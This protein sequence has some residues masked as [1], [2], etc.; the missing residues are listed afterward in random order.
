[1]GAGG[2]EMARYRAVLRSAMIKQQLTAA[3][4]SGVEQVWCHEVGGSRLLHGVSIRQ[5]FPGHPIQA[6]TIAA[7]CGASVYASKFIVVVDEDVDVTNLDHLMWAVV[8]RTEPRESIHFID[9]SWDS[10]ADP[11]LDPARRAAK[12]P[13]HSVAVID[14]CRPWHWRDK[15]APA[16][17]P[18]AETTRLARER[19]GWLIDGALREKAMR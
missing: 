17:S 11:R 7:Q 14:A 9:G 5:R 12:N 6:G 3:G 13:T 15:F 16:N 4:V 18:T 10:P 19:F 1:M 8:T 2:D